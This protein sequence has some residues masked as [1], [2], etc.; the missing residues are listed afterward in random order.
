[1]YGSALDAASSKGHGTIAGLLLEKEADAN[2]WRRYF[3]SALQVAAFEGHDAVIQLLLENG[4]D[5][6]AQG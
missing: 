6:N 1:M 5:V 4:A 3:G 2:S